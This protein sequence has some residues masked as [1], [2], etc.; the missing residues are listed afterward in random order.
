MSNQPGSKA[1]PIIIDDHPDPTVDPPPPTPSL[2]TLKIILTPLDIKT[3]PIKLIL[4]SHGPNRTRVL[5]P[6]PTR[7]CKLCP[8][9]LDHYRSTKISL[10]QLR[11]DVGGPICGYRRC[12]KHKLRFLRNELRRTEASIINFFDLHLRNHP[13]CASLRDIPH[14]Y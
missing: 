11:V 14:R 10:N 7:H 2:P 12:N 9:I 13:R 4:I 8:H 1:D 5:T 3:T 6:H